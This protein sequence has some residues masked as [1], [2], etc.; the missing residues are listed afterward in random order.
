MRL[1]DF[2]VDSNERGRVV[3]SPVQA[4]EPRLVAVNP[5]MLHQ[6][7][8]LIQDKLEAICARSRGRY[9][10]PGILDR[11]A[12]EHW[13][14]WLVWDGEKV[15]A[16]LATE[17]YFDVSNVKVCMI[18][19]CTGEGAKGWVHLIEQIEDYARIEGCEKFDLVARKGW[20]KYLPSM[21][22]THVRLEKDL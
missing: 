19:F 17:L 14:I 2:M 9:S 3:S 11:V 5:R 7:L 22:M 10:M 13:I 21:K 12:R 6:L 8:P 15:L 4:R 18:R 16:V 1:D 20:A